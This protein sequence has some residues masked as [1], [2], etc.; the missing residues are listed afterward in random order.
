MKRSG[1]EGRWAEIPSPRARFALEAA[2]L[3]VVAAGA[4]LAR[5][6][7]QGII[8]L[9]LVAWLLVA[10]IERASS[11]EHAKALAGPREEAPP[12]PTEEPEIAAP[13]GRSWLFGRGRQEAPEPLPEPAAPLEERPSRAHVTRLEPEVAEV[14][15][16]TTDMIVEVPAPRP[17][18]TKRPLE[19]PGLEETEPEPA[20][21]PPV[22]ASGP[23]EGVSGEPGGSSAMDEEPE[24]VEPAPIPAAPAYQPPPTPPPTPREWNL[25]DLERRAREQAGEAARDEEWTALFVHLREFANADGVLPMEFDNL[26]RESFAELIQAA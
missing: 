6:S 23:G 7:P 10:L 20:A 11:R 14:A 9:M 17:A 5:L 8:G 26:V 21:E 3:I 18:V 1:R 16:E 22:R 15:I 4:A 2:F 25:W 24:R 12:P 19:L 13:V